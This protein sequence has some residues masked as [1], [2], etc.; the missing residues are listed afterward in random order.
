MNGSE[1]MNDSQSQSQDANTDSQSGNDN[2][3]QSTQQD[4]VMSVQNLLNK[5]RE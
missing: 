1:M 5:G 2:G 3:G 4:A